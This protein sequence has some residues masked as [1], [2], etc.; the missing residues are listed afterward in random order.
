MLYWAVCQNSFWRT[1]FVK[2]RDVTAEDFTARLNREILVLDGAMGT[3]IMQ[4]LSSQHRKG[5]DICSQMS[6]GSLD[7]LVL[8]EPG[9]IE[10]IH[11]AYLE[12]G[13]NIITTNTFNANRFSISDDKVRDINRKGAE[14][15]REA[16]E[17]YYLKNNIPAEKRPIVAGCMGPTAVS[18]SKC[19]DGGCFDA[20]AGAYAEQ[21]QG[22]IEGGVDILL[23]ETVFDLRNAEAAVAGVKMSYR[24]M[25]K[26]LPLIISA[27]LNEDGRLYSGHT[28]EEFVDKFSSSESIALGLNCGCGACKMISQVERLAESY[29]GFIAVYPNAGI[30]DAHVH[31]ND[32]PEMMARTLKPLLDKRLI[33]IIGGCC[34][35]TPE[36]IRL[37]SDMVKNIS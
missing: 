24:N 7:R 36:H 30:P 28:I 1:V 23:L 35:T 3:M 22:L 13:A 6:A 25:C 4:A 16:V 34:G 27:A 10:R 15:A 26:Q 31:Y 9:L 14:L 18:L 33:K 37:I 5:S 8:S 11:S 19:K 21:A 12:A 2:H 20:M 17:S 32:I 29:H